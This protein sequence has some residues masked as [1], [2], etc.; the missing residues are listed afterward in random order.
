LV[1]GVIARIYGLLNGVLKILAFPASIEVF[2]FGGLLIISRLL[3][4]SIG[5]KQTFI[6][7]SFLRGQQ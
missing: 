3:V 4:I 6:I 2:I 7:H 5:F 1:C